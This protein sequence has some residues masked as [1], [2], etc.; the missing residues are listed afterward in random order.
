[1]QQKGFCKVEAVVEDGRSGEV[2][3]TIAVGICHGAVAVIRMAG[4]SRDGQARTRGGDSGGGFGDATV[5]G[6]VARGLEQRLDC[7]GVGC[8]G[9]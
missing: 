9:F 7:K 8:V 3:E 5:H 6:T 4:R 1:M 2:G